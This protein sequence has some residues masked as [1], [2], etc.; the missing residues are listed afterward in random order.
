MSAAQSRIWADHRLRPESSFYNINRLVYVQ[1][2]L[3]VD[4]LI[5]AIETVCLAHDSLRFRFGE[6]DGVPFQTVSESGATPVHLQ[7]F[8]ALGDPEAA[9][10][11]YLK[12]EQTRP[13]DLAAEGPL[14]VYV[15]RRAEEAYTMLFQTHH[16]VSDWWAGGIFFKALSQAYNGRP[17]FR[18]PAAQYQ[19]YVERQLADGGQR[20]NADTQVLSNYLGRL[21]QPLNL[22]YRI[23]PEIPR[24]TGHT[25][26]TLV[27]NAIQSRLRAQTSSL[28][29]TEYMFLMAALACVLHRWT[30]TTDFTVGVYVADRSTPGTGEIIGLLF[31]GLPVRVT[32]DS[33][34]T[35]ANIVGQVR[36]G[37]LTLLAHPTANPEELARDLH[38]KGSDAGPLFNVTFQ[39]YP[40][41]G[42]APT[43]D[44][45]ITRG[46][47]AVQ[48]TLHDL[49]AYAQAGPSGLNLRIQYDAALFDPDDVVALVGAW[50]GLLTEAATD[51]RQ[52]VREFQLKG[53]ASHPLMS[54]VSGERVPGS[55][56]DL[57]AA[58]SRSFAEHGDQIALRRHGAPSASWSYR[59]LDEYSA[60]VAL[61]LSH[62]VRPGD[63]VAILEPVH[64]QLVAACLGAVKS[65][66]TVLVL[67]PH[68]PVERLR[69]MLRDARARVL[70]CQSS[71]SAL[72][73]LPPHLPRMYL[74][75]LS[76]GRATGRSPIRD[77][78]V[79]EKMACGSLD[80]DAIAALVYTSGSRGRPKGVALTHR[81]LLN[82]ADH[83]RGLLGLTTGTRMCV[84]LPQQF[85]TFPLQVL[86]GLLAGAEITLFPREVL[87]DPADLMASAYG[88]GI[89]VIE[90]SVAGLDA[91]LYDN[92]QRKRTVDTQRLRSI[93]V[94]GEKLRPRLALRVR[95]QLPR[96]QLVN[97]YG[98]TETCGMIA[99]TVVRDPSWFNEGIPTRN[100]VLE[101][102]DPL[103]RVV[104]RG[105][106][107]QLRVSGS[108]VAS[109]Y[110]QKPQLTAER[111][112]SG[113][114]GRAV[115]TG[116]LA[117]MAADGSVEILGRLDDQLSLRGFR[118]EPAEICRVI[119]GYNG[120]SKCEVVLWPQDE[121]D[122]YLAAYLLAPSTLSRKELRGYCL[123]HVP[124]YMVPRAFVVVDDF[125]RGPTGKVDR[126]ALPRPRELVAPS[127]EPSTSM[128]TALASIWS[129]I[130][131]TEHVTAESDFFELGGQSLAAVR[132]VARI[133]AVLGVKL[134]ANAVFE[135]P[136]LEILAR[137]V[138][139]SAGKHG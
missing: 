95:E 14:R 35:F 69:Y 70:V 128:E 53:A 31:E 131:G 78:E 48:G 79:A 57:I 45:V 90:L 98:M 91:Y 17:V 28:A 46:S 37:V 12:R 76:L 87:Q 99:S 85:V 21:L 44:G 3:D 66:A 5:R 62:T 38:N 73:L 117:R 60:E 114:D 120:V 19:T 7:D 58:L 43:L 26:Q 10:R 39:L 103:S 119:E 61:A 18:N 111:F 6:I 24:R 51:P 81:G 55:A 115:L 72:P 84:S 113:Q 29:A 32:F 25:A 96:V 132:V 92:E 52:P 118:I 15:I 71:C 100:C 108:Q 22:P 107:G 122:G 23:H 137:H 68:E 75:D 80:A 125:P 9:A 47:R 2:S 105:W 36:R 20:I 67:D 86:S 56:T 88:S 97:A 129:Q 93:L 134:A 1:G 124:P 102:I 77:G 34:T 127:R 83:R 106:A 133:D 135:F 94:A 41:R 89:E 49:M 27:S 59:Q 65:G 74:D 126:S 136:T 16:I 139:E 54:R 121:G 123:E 116:D 112:T 40:E 30:G 13:I 8:R 109:G 64:Q 130:L 63:T 11:D 104:P 42:N 101:I 82:Q 138:S 110:W 33:E 4:R 50:A